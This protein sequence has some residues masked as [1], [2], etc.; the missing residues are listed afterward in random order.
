[1]QTEIQRQ[2]DEV[3]ASRYDFDPQGL[4][5]KALDRAVAMMEGRLPGEPDELPL[6]VLD[7]GCGT[8][9][10][11]EKL[12]NAGVKLQPYGLDLSKKMVE[13]AHTRIPD[14]VSEVDDAAKLD[15]YFPEGNFDLV[16]THFITGFVPLEVLAPKVHQKLAPGGL[17]SVM[18]A[19]RGGFPELQRKASSAPCR[20]LF[21]KLDVAKQVCVPAD[22]NEV[23]RTLQQHGYSVRHCENVRLPV[24]FRTFDEFMEFAYF[25]GWLTPFIEAVGLHKAGRVVRFFMDSFFFPVQDHHSIFLVL[26]EKS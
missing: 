25:G 2:Y 10:W 11:L 7:L 15:D 23:A 1:M 3:I 18:G 12:R 24:S 6:K 4:T 14:L 9:L 26:G 21:G 5:G 22:Q 13:V 19:T 8:G 20:W 17:W 16:G